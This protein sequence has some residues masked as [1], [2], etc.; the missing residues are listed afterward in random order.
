[1]R[2]EHLFSSSARPTQMYIYTESV[3][4]LVCVHA[5]VHLT[6]CSFKPGLRIWELMCCCI[7]VCTCTKIQNKK[8]RTYKKM[9]TDKCIRLSNCVRVSA[10]VCTHDGGISECV[11][12]SQR[13]RRPAG[14]APSRHPSGLQPP[15][16]IW[17]LSEQQRRTTMQL[18]CITRSL[19]TFFFLRVPPPMSLYLLS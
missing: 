13:Q 1:M 10:C 17:R 16:D 9:C 4:V 5:R 12:G 15:A 19:K 2:G 18:Q 8:K 7:Q 3:C 11:L 14:S 6:L